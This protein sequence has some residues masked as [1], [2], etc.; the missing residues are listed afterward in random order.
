[1]GWCRDDFEL[2]DGAGP[3]AGRRR[4]LMR[5]SAWAWTPRCG[6]G[7]TGARATCP[8]SRSARWC[9]AAASAASWPR[10]PQFAVGDMV[11]GLPGWQEYAVVRDDGLSTLDRH[12]RRPAA[13]AQ[14]VR[15]HRAAAYF[16]LTDVGEAKAGETVV[17]SAAAGATGSIVGA[18]RQDHGLPGRGHRGHRR[19]VRVG[20][21]RAR[22]RRVHQP[23]HRRPAGA[24]TR[25]VPQARRRVLRQRRR[26]DPRRRARPHLAKH[27]R[28]VLCG[29]ISV[30]NDAGPPAGPARTTST[31]SRAGAAWRA[32]SP[33]T[34][35]T[36]ST[37]SPSSSREWVDEGK[38]HCRIHWFEGLGTPP[39]PSTPCSPAR[40]SARS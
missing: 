20:G 35:G 21:R 34:A 3:G 17:V 31:S 36:A 40:T 15:G 11:Y 29:A 33:S 18:D 16:G 1:M 19:E 4:G 10:E 24:P 39:R 38:L 32:S 2:V 28:V 7:S 5:T 23:P 27:G 14:R 25:A 12:R 9:A 30:Y 13:D 37:R 8:R 22:L 26:R 6:P